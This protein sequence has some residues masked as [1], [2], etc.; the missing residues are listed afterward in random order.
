MNKR[1]YLMLPAALLSLTLIAACGNQSQSGAVT[2]EIT[3]LPDASNA[4][5][6]Q[7]S[8]E[9]RQTADEAAGL[10]SSGESLAINTGTLSQAAAPPSGSGSKSTAKNTTADYI[11]EEKAKQLALEHAGVKESD[12]TF[13][14]V[15]LDYDDGIAEYEVEFYVANE[16]Y[17]YDIDAST[18]AIRS[19]DYELENY[20]AAI[21]I[22][23]KD[24]NDNGLISETDAK[25]I[26]LAKVSGASESN[27]RI[28]LDYDDGK[29]V[30]EGKIIYEEIEYEFEIDAATGN[31]LEW[32]A[33][34]VY[35]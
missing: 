8:V 24:S 18:G 1:K 11:G 9:A 5:T 26:A 21:N 2:Q 28:K 6:G 34:S 32:D 10:P 23:D 16:E 4:D 27:I 22:P 13:V 7:A 17:D 35:D 25:A 31:F 15:K 19:F 29:T 3:S 33:E 20:P 14:H 30:Y 12:A